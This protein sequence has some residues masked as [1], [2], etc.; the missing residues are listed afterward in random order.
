MNLPDLPERILNLAQRRIVRKLFYLLHMHR[1][2]VPART[3]PCREP[4]IRS[5][6]LAV[7][8]AFDSVAE[9][10]KIVGRSVG[11]LEEFREQ[12]LDAVELDAE[13]AG[14]EVDVRGQGGDLVAGLGAQGDFHGGGLE[15]FA[16]AFE[17]G[18]QPPTP[19]L[20]MA[21]RLAVSQGF[22]LLDQLLAVDEESSAGLVAAEAVE[23]LDGLPAFEAEEFFDHGTVEDGDREPAEF[24]DDAG[25]VK[26]PKGLRRQGAFL[27]SYTLPHSCAD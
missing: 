14:L 4:S 23:Q 19:A 8:C 9:A 6:L 15:V 7:L 10:L 2:R 27:T 21:E 25:K 24:L 18:H 12:V 3:A 11:E 20:L 13:P 1:W 26:Q 5:N 17:L 22:E 16:N